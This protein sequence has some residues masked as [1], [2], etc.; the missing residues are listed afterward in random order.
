MSNFARE[1]RIDRCLILDILI[2][3]A[4][5]YCN[6]VMFYYFL[7]VAIVFSLKPACLTIYSSS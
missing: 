6:D 1:K 5:E 4:V 2:G 7:S 3:W